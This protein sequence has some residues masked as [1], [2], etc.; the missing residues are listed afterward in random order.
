VTEAAIAATYADARRRFLAAAEQAQA[1][2][3]SVVHPLTGPEG[4]D[5]A[6]D[7]AELGSIDAPALLFIVS[8]THGVEGFAGSALQTRWLQRAASGLPPS[9]R[10]VHVHALN[11]YG[12]AWTRRVNEDNV[13]LNRNFVDWANPPAGS[14]GYD[15]LADVLVPL[16]WDEATQSE[17]LTFLLSELQRVGL[18]ELQATIS[19][20]QYRHAG[21]VFY[22]GTGPVWSQRQLRALA[23][24][25]ACGAER[26]AIVDLHTG[27]GPWGHGE[28]IAHESR[29]DPAYLRAQKWW[30]D[31]HSMVD[32]ESVSVL[33]TGDWLGST[34][35]L[36]PG[37]EI[38]AAA[39]E[40]GTVDPVTVLQALR[41]NAWLHHHG[42]A[43]GPQG[44]GIR[45]Q[46]RAAF[47]DDDPAWFSAIATRFDAVIDAAAANLG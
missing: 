11:P 17:S 21:G 4:E 24:A 13:D 27:L 39:L 5:L 22:G 35:Q 46:V 28:L 18:E 10:V 47:I 40:F 20:G 19:S 33:L 43:K 23:S 9:V 45:A 42:D 32:G 16:L 12:F 37:A 41:A 2:M 14:E 29:I 31:V 38:T 3:T 30:G 44:D 26:V 34:A 25:H 6:I 1:S 7:V 8:G 15:R 36:F